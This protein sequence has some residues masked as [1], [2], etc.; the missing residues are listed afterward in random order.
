MPIAHPRCAC[1]A[2]SQEEDAEADLSS[3]GG[4]DQES[5]LIRY[6]TQVKDEEGLLTLVYVEARPNR[7]SDPR[8]AAPPDTTH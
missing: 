4:L 5:E 1:N 2:P 3:Y 8:R 6:E 7:Q